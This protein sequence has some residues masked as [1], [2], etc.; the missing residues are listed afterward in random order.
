M[1][2]VCF[3]FVVGYVFYFSCMLCMIKYVCMIRVIMYLVIEVD[4]ECRNV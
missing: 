2:L 3:V 1:D 4:Y